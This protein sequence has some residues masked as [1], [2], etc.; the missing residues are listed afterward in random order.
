MKRVSSMRNQLIVITVLAA[1][2]I[3]MCL[4]TIR[5]HVASLEHR[6][7]AVE[8][9]KD[10]VSSL[11]LRLGVV[12]RKIESD[13]AKLEDGADSQVEGI[14]AMQSYLLRE[15]LPSED[16]EDVHAHQITQAERPLSRMDEAW[17][18]E[19]PSKYSYIAKVKEGCGQLCKCN[20]DRRDGL[21]FDE[22]KVPVHCDALFDTDVFVQFGH[23]QKEAPTQLPPEWKEDFTMG[24]K[25]PVVG[26]YYLNDMYLGKSAKVSNW[27][28]KLVNNMVREAEKG[29]LEGT[30]GRNETNA[31]QRALE[32]APHL[33]G[34]RALVIGSEDPWVE[35]CVLGA[36]ALHVTTLEYGKI[37]STHSKIST[38]TPSEFQEQFQNG[39]IEPFDA[40]VTF[41]SLEHPGLG[42]YGDAL[43]P[44][45]D[46]LEIARSWCVTKPGGSLTIGLPYRDN[47]EQWGPEGIQ[48]NAH[49][50]YGEVRYPCLTSNWAQI[51]TEAN[52]QQIFILQKE[53][54]R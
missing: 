21:F 47:G 28:P 41:S 53:L 19:N 32:R 17:P 29:V 27:T 25:Y 16:A 43:N 2:F 38:I 42:R 46:I 23:G 22:V 5:S 12:E 34:G 14:A 52:G 50:V 8:Q 24:G 10:D 7:G 4:F 1:M 3:A 26:D 37:L 44:W 35:A 9:N 11:E 31:L 48:Y 13:R 40:V 45:A 49:R 54:T 39:L 30:Y 6:L 20:G 36:G 15:R 51:D 33:K 18:D